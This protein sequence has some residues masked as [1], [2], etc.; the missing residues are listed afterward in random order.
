M[1]KDATPHTGKVRT[2]VASAGT[3]KTHN[4]VQSIAETIENGTSPEKILATTFTVKA[5]DELRGSAA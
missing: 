4:V 3:G 5:A 2:V 1:T